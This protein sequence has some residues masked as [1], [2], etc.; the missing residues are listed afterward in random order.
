MNNTDR[1]FFTTLAIL[2]SKLAHLLSAHNHLHEAA[3]ARLD[4]IAPLLS[5]IDQEGE[6]LLIG[7]TK[8]GGH[9]L[10][11]HPTPKRPKLGNTLVVAP[12]QGGKSLLAIA[13]LLTWRHSVIVN[14]IKGELRHSTSGWRKTFSDVKIIDPTGYGNRF[15]PL[16]GLTTEDQFYSIATQLLFTPHEGDG[17]A[18]SL[19]AMDMLT[20]LFLAA[21]DQGVPHFSYVHETLATGLI[22]TAQRLQAVNPAY[23]TRFMDMT[24]AQAQQKNFDDKYLLNSYGLLKAKLRPILTE[25]VIRS[26]SGSDFHA[27]DLICSDKPTTVYLQWPEE[28]LLALAPLVRLMVGSLINGMIKAARTMGESNCKPVLVLADEAGR[29]AIPSLAEHATTV[30]SKNISLW[31]SMQDLSQL[32]TNYGK[33]RAD[34]LKNNMD[35]KIF[36]RQSDETTTQFLERKLQKRSGFAHS[37]TAKPGDEPVDGQSE[38]AIPLLRSDKIEQ[39]DDTEIIAFHH[40]LPPLHERRMDW[41]DFPELVK[42]RNMPPV[43]PEPLPKLPATPVADTGETQATDKQDNQPFTPVASEKLTGW[44]DTPGATIYAGGQKKPNHPKRVD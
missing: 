19:R 10:S 38:Q 36:Y 39:M 44:H 27:K 33:S 15:N 21:R 29:T 34:T 42:R 4:Q 6:G 22:A 17:A 8:Q 13:Q 23:A 32:E 40:N 5:T 1:Q 9:I 41:R 2:K 3:F 14:D 7:T 24:Y 20:A 26:L 18:F 37:Q 11:V 16:D 30:V 31:V 25:T 43:K 28:D 35:T 12:T